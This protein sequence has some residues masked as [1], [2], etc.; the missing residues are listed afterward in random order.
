MAAMLCR[1]FSFAAW[2]WQ[3]WGGRV[4]GRGKRG[5]RAKDMAA[6]LCR[7]FSFAAWFWQEWGGKG[8]GEEERVGGGEDMAAML[9]RTFSF[10]AWSWQGESGGKGEGERGGRD[11]HVGGGWAHQMILEGTYRGDGGQHW[12]TTLTPTAGSLSH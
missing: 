11:S 1:T 9:C 4:R 5:G 3:E 10:A 6:M 7:T 2:S 8:E 12:T